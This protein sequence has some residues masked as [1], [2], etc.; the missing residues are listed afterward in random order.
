MCHFT[1]VHGEIFVSHWL[2]RLLAAAGICW[3]IVPQLARMLAPAAANAS[4]PRAVLAFRLQS[5]REISYVLEYIASPTL[6][7]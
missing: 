6:L 7:Y 2:G 3:D 1:F 5:D 4:P